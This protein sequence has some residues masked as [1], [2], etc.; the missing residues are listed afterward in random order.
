MGTPPGPLK[1]S[2]PKELGSVIYTDEHIMQFPVWDM[3]SLQREGD[4][5]GRKEAREEGR[6]DGRWAI[7]FLL[8]QL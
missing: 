2:G 4:V 5:P 7:F 3:C 8:T 6:K 1:H